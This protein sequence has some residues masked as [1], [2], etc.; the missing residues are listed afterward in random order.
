MVHQ[1]GGSAAARGERDAARG[2]TASFSQAGLPVLAFQVPDGMH[3]PSLID[4]LRQH[5]HDESTPN[6]GPNHVFTGE[7]EYEGG[8]G[9]DPA[10][11]QGQRVPGAEALGPARIAIL[12][13]GYDQAVKS[14]H[15]GLAE[16]LEHDG[17][18][19]PLAGDGHLAHE[20]GHGTFIA[21]IVMKLAPELRIRQV[22]VLD[23]AGVGDD[24]TI[25][26]GLALSREAVLNLSLGGYTHDGQP[27]VALATALAQLDDSVAVVAAAGNNA[28]PEP[29][30]PAAFKRVV[31][32]GAL[33]T[34]GDGPPS[35]RASATTGT[36][37]TSMPPARACTACTW[38][39]ATWRRTS[40]WRT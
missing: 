20:A 16:R 5:E 9:C 3:I 14:L 31:A 38:T 27:P 30:W 23:P 6:V 33:D 18:E 1:H 32:V 21:G 25:A 36:G 37:W 40:T 39:A 8:P 15:P 26:A 22:R 13:T 28:S 35:G 29:F 34:T 2:V 17:D 7:Y 12:D 24:A 10:G 4:R 11:P 19:D